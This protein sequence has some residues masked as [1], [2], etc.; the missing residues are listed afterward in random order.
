MGTLYGEITQEME[1]SE[2]LVHGY[3]SIIMIFTFNS[4]IIIQVVII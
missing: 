2:S 4:S 3:F 1:I